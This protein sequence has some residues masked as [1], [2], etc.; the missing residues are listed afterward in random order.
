MTPGGEK[1]GKKKDTYFSC[2]RRGKK[3]RKKNADLASMATEGGKKERQETR[4]FE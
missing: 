3:E 4:P 2:S 1:R